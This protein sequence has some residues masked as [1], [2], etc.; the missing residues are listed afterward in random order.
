MVINVSPVLTKHT[1]THKNRKKLKNSFKKFL[2]FLILSA[3]YVSDI[4]NCFFK[5][6]FVI[7]LFFRNGEIRGRR[8]L[9]K[10]YATKLKKVCRFE[11]SIKF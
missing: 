3:K 1:K 5:D 8:R 11:I 6:S 10:K 4:T 9:L 7:R 2:T